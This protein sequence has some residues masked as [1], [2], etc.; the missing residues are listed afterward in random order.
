MAHGRSVIQVR[1]LRKHREK[2]RCTA[3]I[4]NSC[5][6][7]YIADNCLESVLPFKFL[8]MEISG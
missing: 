5:Y 4:K 6:L 2:L 1:L 8:T 7:A 3:G